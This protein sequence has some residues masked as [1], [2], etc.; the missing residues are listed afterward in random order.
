MDGYFDIGK[1]VNTQGVKGDVRVIP[2]TDEPT[3]FE[4]LNE[5]AVYTRNGIKTMEIEKVWYHKKFVIIKFKNIDDMTAGEK[6]KESIIRIPH[7]QGL[8]LEKDEYYIKDIIGI[9]VVTED[10]EVL[11]HVEDIL[12]TGANDV[13]VIGKLLLP[14]IKQCIIDIDLS[15]KKMTV[16]LLKGLLD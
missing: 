4:R 13:Y 14:A 1:I 8:P 9:E 12:N 10:G 6:L 16:K 11:G 5:V 15:T 7:A 3:R 2:L